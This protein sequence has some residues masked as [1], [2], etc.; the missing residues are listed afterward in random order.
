MRNFRFGIIFKPRRKKTYNY[1]SDNSVEFY[2]N[3]TFR[4]TF[5]K[6]ISLIRKDISIVRAP[7]LISNIK[8][9]GDIWW[10]TN[11]K[12]LEYFDTEECKKI[13]TKFIDIF[14]NDLDEIALELI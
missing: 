9:E 11:E 6:Y 2:D 14:N 1:L 13:L 4:S 3:H 5:L 12:S 10:K 8:S 7:K